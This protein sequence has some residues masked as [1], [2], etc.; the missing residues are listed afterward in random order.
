MDVDGVYAS[1]IS[2]PFGPQAIA[3]FDNT[4]LLLA[5][6]TSQGFTDIA[7]FLC[8]MICADIMFFHIRKT[9]TISSRKSFETYDNPII[10]KLLIFQTG[11]IRPEPPRLPAHRCRLSGVC[12]VCSVHA[13]ATGRV[14][15]RPICRWSSR[16]RDIR[17]D[18]L[19]LAPWD[20]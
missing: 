5:W 19:L 1:Q 20:A 14:R 16:L 2:I 8:S 6:T 17:S 10:S 4:T 15:T 3:N 7:F 18:A 11:S 9:T 12:L 13:D